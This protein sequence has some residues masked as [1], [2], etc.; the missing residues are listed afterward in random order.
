M[1][2]FLPL[3]VLILAAACGNSKRAAEEEESKFKEGDNIYEPYRGEEDLIPTPKQ[4]EH[5]VL[6]TL[7]SYHPYCGGM[8]PTEEMLAR[9]TAPFSNTTFIFI[10]KNTGEN[11][12]M[13]TDEN[14]MFKLNLDT[15]KYAIREVHK[16]TT[17]EAFYA[18]NVGK[19]DD[20]YDSGSKE[21]YEKWWASNFVEFQISKTDSVY[22]ISKT[23][24][25]RCFTGINP[26]ST[27]NGP[28]PP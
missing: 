27:Y 6:I 5:N 12:R 11:K 3:L 14:G 7:Y 25:A 20:Y 21:C 28:Y 8:A 10:D 17:F 18:Q 15:G 23:Q 22:E 16:D 2:T 4:Q 9:Q 1:K 26:C 19:S 13:N 24:Y